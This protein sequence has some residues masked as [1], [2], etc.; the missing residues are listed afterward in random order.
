MPHFSLLSLPP[1]PLICPSPFSFKFTA[2]VLI[3]IMCVRA[4]T[5]TH[6][7]LNIIHLVHMLLVRMFLGMTF[8]HWTIGVLFWGMATCPAPAFL[9]CHWSFMWA[10]GLWA[11]P[12]SLACP[13][14]S[15][16]KRHTFGSLRLISCLLLK[17][18]FQMDCNFYR[19]SP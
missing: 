10:G 11:S 6:T 7:F 19:F 16:F 1:N 2:S 14:V 15:S 4:H 12:S 17:Q 13:L 9:S 8:W 5:H 18:A 3:V